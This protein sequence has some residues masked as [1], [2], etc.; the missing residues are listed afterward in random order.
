MAFIREKW[1]ALDPNHPFQYSFL[2]ETFDALFRQVEQFIRIF[3]YAAALA[4]FIACLGLFGLAAFAADRRTKEI[5]IRKV[6]GASVL[7]IFRLLSGEIVWLILIAFVLA[8][9][10][11]YLAMHEILQNFAYRIG[12]GW[13]IFALAG[14]LALIIAMVTVSMQAIRAA[15]AKPADSLRY[16]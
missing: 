16:E 9:P 11:A 6:L 7:Q 1:E 4:I 8:S 3:G 15:L 5:G 12:M 2:D 10:L 13:W 14:G